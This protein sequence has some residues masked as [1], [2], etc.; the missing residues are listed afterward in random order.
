MTT[1]HHLSSYRHGITTTRRTSGDRPRTGRRSTVTTSPLHLPDDAGW[2]EIRIQGRLN[3]RWSTVL[4]GM[5]LVPDADGTTLIHGHVIDQA[6]LHGLL[7]RLRDIGLPLV[8]VI[9]VE[10]DPATETPHHD[11][12][13]D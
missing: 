11:S 2:Y 1:N 9:R 8:S 13:G 10:P 7:V 12:T 5:H 6:A 3:P 4:D